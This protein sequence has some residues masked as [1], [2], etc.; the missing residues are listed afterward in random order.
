[1]PRQKQPQYLGTQRRALWETGFPRCLMWSSEGIILPGSRRGGGEET[2]DKLLSEGAREGAGVVVSGGGRADKLRL[3]R[4]RALFS[5]GKAKILFFP[6]LLISKR[7]SE[8]P[9]PNHHVSLFCST[10]RLRLNRCW[11]ASGT[12]MGSLR[13]TFQ[14]VDVSRP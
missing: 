8:G 14:L 13:S 1:M 12:M 4:A 2:E 5:G 11:V 7:K 9:T 10:E 6:S 3:H